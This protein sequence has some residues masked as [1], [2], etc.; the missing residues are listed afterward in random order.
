M[1]KTLFLMCGP[2][3]VG[4]TTWIKAHKSKQDVRIS[5]D[6][7]RFKLLKDGEDYFSHEKEVFSIFI[8][9]INKYIEDISFTGNIYVDATHLNEKV[10]TNYLID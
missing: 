1:S 5:R 3:G 7:I 6:D 4:K 8:K 10:A 2:A 9:T